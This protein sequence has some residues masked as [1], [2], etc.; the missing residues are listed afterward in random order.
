MLCTVKPVYKD[1]LKETRKVVFIG[2]WSLCTGS[3]STCFNEKPFSRETSNVVFEDRWSF[4]TGG[5]SIQ[6]VI[7]AGL[8]VLL[9]P[10]CTSS[11]RGNKTSLQGH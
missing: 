7:R 2:R 3:F 1:Y 8:T 4:Y 10:V 6:V 9:N 11:A 5:L